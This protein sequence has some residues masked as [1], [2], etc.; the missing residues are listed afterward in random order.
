M[1]SC[2]A[3]RRLSLAS[4]I[5]AAAFIASFA[6]TLAGTSL[7]QDIN[8]DVSSW[9]SLESVLVLPPVYRPDGAANSES[10][11]TVGCGAGCEA[12]SQPDTSG[13]PRAVAGTADNP[14]NSSAGTADDP[15]DNPTADGPTTED[16]TS[17]QAAVSSSDQQSVDNLDPSVGS[18][19]DYEAQATTQEFGSAGVGQTPTVII[20]APISPYYVPGTLAL[21][22]SSAIRTSPA[23][24]PQPMARVAPLP[25][26][27]PHGIPRTI[28]GFPGGR[29]GTF[30]FSHMS[31][32]H[33]GFGRR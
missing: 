12:S 16:P 7:A 27:V 17:Q 14:A 23:W 19:E 18:A 20:V 11:P 33:G 5:V 32:F 6:I 1:E 30:G 3:I 15:A 29:F 24:M 26:I 21:P 28:G 25:S 4:A 31:T 2:S 9:D 8:K 22:A 10:D 13:L